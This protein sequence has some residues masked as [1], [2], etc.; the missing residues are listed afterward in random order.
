MKFFYILY[1]FEYDIPTTLSPPHSTV[2]ISITTEPIAPSLIAFNGIGST[3]AVVEHTEAI[4]YD[5]EG[6]YEFYYC[7]VYGTPYY[8]YIPPTPA[9]I[10][11]SQAPQGI[12]LSLSTKN[13]FFL[14]SGEPPPFIF[15]T[16]LEGGVLKNFFGLCILLSRDPAGQV[17]QPL[18]QEIGLNLVGIEGTVVK[19][20]TIASG[21]AKIYHT[22]EEPEFF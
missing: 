19:I 10:S 12:S 7:T 2:S 3:T 1:Y 9:N 14:P 5:I 6:E 11:L 16:V 18:S 22:Q 15:H 17:Y 4:L 13:I 20:V 8:Y 21:E